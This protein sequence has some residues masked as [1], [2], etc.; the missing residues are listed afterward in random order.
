MVFGLGVFAP[1]GLRTE[2]DGADVYSGRFLNQRAV[3][4]SI[5][6][7]PTVAFKLADRLSLGVGFDFRL[8]EMNLRRKVPTFNPFTQNVA[9]IARA[10]LNSGW[11]SGFG[12]NLGLLAK[13]SDSW[14]VGLTYRHKVNVDFSGSAVFT[15][16]PT[17][18]TQLDAL[19][20]STLP[21]GA[22]PLTTKI[23]F[24]ATFSGGLAYST[25]NWTFSAEADRFQWSSFGELPLLFT[26]RPELSQTLAENYENTWTFRLGVERRIGRTWAVRGGY[27]R[28]PSPAPAASLSPI[29][30]DSDRN[31]FCLGGS[32]TNGRIRF[33]LGS[34]YVKGSDRSTAGTSRDNYNGTYRASAI[35]FGASFGYGF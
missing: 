19:V 33:D 23:A 6:I 10:E 26:A 20:A 25:D 32:W 22:T 8:A 14:S 27:F 18:N 28:D 13:P 17:G 1:F 24:P 30:P 7:N 11:G 9:D 12:F 29:L 31:G 21:Q 3:L 16:V 5:A 15:Q 35:A 2:W 34:W 4:K